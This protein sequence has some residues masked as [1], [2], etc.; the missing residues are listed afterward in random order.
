MIIGMAVAHGCSSLE[1]SIGFCR[2]ARLLRRRNGSLAAPGG[3][4]NRVV[5]LAAHLLAGLAP[6]FGRPFDQRHAAARL[7]G[8]DRPRCRHPWSAAAA[9]N[10]RRNSPVST[11]LLMV[12]SVEKLRPVETLMTSSATF[13]SRPKRSPDDQ[14][15]GGPPQSRPQPRSCSAPSARGPTRCR[16][17]RT[18]FCPIAI[19]TGRAALQPRRIVSYRP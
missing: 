6:P 13:G 15:L 14:R 4:G 17:S 18:L 8:R 3:V 2:H 10:R 7:L 12:L 11:W 16:R 9:G 5:L 19:S 1:F